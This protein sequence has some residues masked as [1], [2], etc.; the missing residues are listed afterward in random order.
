M[1]YGPAVDGSFKISGVLIH[2]NCVRKELVE[3][4][5]SV[6]NPGANVIVELL[7]VEE[8]L[9]AQGGF[10]VHEIKNGGV[11]SS[12]WVVLIFVNGR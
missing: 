8:R 1:V 6:G 9:L 2:T 3:F 10:K 12:W 11:F 5:V 4:V 7:I